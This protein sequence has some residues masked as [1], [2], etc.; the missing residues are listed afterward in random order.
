MSY[1]ELSIKLFQSELVAATIS[2]LWEFINVLTAT[3][4]VWFKACPTPPKD[5][6]T[7]SLDNLSITLEVALTIS[8]E[9]SMSLFLF[10][11]T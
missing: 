4:I 11:F 10:I 3:G 6:E 9:S 5:L 8:G 7:A 1:P 2:S